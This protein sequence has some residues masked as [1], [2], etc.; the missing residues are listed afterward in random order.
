[1]M[2]NVDVIFFKGSKG[3]ASTSG[4]SRLQ[5]AHLI[6]GVDL[7]RSGEQLLCGLEEGLLLA[8]SF[9]F[10]LSPDH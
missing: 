5:Q 7:F 2:E 6:G 1:M 10:Q 9:S 8:Y 4:N 3:C